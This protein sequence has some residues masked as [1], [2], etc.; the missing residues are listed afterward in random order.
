MGGCAIRHYAAFIASAYG[1]VNPL[2]MSDQVQD[3][4]P[5]AGFAE[6][7]EKWWR[8]VQVPVIVSVC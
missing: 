3:A 1:A 4:R 2:S 5:N 8:E 7:C 6:S